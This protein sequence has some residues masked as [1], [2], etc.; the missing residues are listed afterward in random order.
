MLPG[1]ENRILW[2][3]LLLAFITTPLFGLL[4]GVPVLNF[5]FSEFRFFLRFI[6]LIAVLTV[7]CW[8]IN[9]LLL[10]ASAK[11]G[12]L[13]NIFIRFTIS[14]IT[15]LAFSVL[16]ITAFHK[17][18]PPQPGIVAEAGKPSLNGVFFENS[19]ADRISGPA[20]SV[21]KLM[22]VP[23]QGEGKIITRSFFP[24]PLLMH[25]LTINVIIL[26]LCELV[27]LHFHQQKMESENARLRQSNLEAKNN[28]LKNQLHPHFLFNSLNTLRLLLKKDADKAE[29]YLLKLADILRV[30]TT[31]AEHSI[32]DVTDEL[33]LCLSYLQMQE[34][35]FGDMLLYDV[36]NKKLL[37]A[38]GKLPVFA[39]QLLAENA[40]K[41]N[42]FTN[43]YPL[44]IFI[45]YDEV[46]QLITV[47]NKIR[48]KRLTEVTTQ[49][50]LK[51][52]DERYRLLCNGH[53]AVHNSGDE[54]AVSIKIL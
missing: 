21:L 48:P 14:I 28:Q 42:A 15:C 10:A 12:W 2:R 23:P 3:L 32:T 17:A 51:N 9:I 49:T 13:K 5:N 40:I 35:R 33:N 38:K 11:L 6:G 50:G 25:A 29:T 7:V 45:D 54:F 36:T 24:F 18:S 52:L 27:M 44:H 16:I 8:G 31:S 4:G 43:E 26:I 1:L 46:R 19:K 22:P 37:D 53:I 34:V 41:H 20:D 30:S 47:R 39:L